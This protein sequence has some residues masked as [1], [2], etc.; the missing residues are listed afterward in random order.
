M[1]H[2]EGP[3]K[4]KVKLEKQHLPS[5]ELKILLSHTQYNKIH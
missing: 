1:T 5:I 3:S 2:D 4:G